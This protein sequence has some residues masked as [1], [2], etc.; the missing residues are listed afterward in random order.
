MENLII[1]I[2]E[3]SEN[4]SNENLDYR[5]IFSG[6]MIESDEENE[7]AIAFMNSTLKNPETNIGIKV[8]QSGN[9]ASESAN[10]IDCNQK[11]RNSF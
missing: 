3:I 7:F 5:V 4:P 9:P 6:K 10:S 11:V 2:T 1:P 8:L